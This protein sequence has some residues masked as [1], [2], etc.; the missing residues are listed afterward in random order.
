MKKFS[1]IVLTIILCTSAIFA[2]GA[3]EEAGDKDVTLSVMWFNDANE[4]DVFLDTIQG[5]LE[6]N[7]NV[8]VDMQVVA[9]SEYEQ[10][11][12]LMISG[13]NP[14]DVARVTNN[15][16]ASLGASLEP[17]NNYVDDIEAVKA[18]YMPG[19]IAFAEDKDG[20]LLAYPTEATA[21]GM[22]VNLTAWENA[23]ID[24]RELSK[25]WTWAD[26]EVAV[27][28][29]I[30]AN[31]KMKYG[32][33]LDFSPH[34]FST[35]VFQ[36]GGRFMNS[37]QSAVAADNEGTIAA[38]NMLKKFHDNGVVPTSVWLGSENPAELFQAG[39][40]ACH[41][42]G[43]WNI[44]TYNKNVKDFE[45][46]VVNNPIG[47]VKSSVPGGKFIASFKDSKNKEAAMDLMAAFSAKENN[48]K[49]CADTFNLSARIDAEVPFD[50]NKEDFAVFSE[51]LKVTP[52]YTALEWKADSLN[53]VYSYISEQVVQVLMGNISAE[54]ATRNINK[55]AAKF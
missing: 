32:L 34:R 51:D 21:N 38:I 35:L 11:L 3:K 45:W 5:Y 9:F 14:P 41:I 31:D 15:H 37:D 23:G 48:E 52:A 19:S 22:L 44:N 27:R 54:E 39:L 7:P 42:G 18:D 24:V 13:G 53:K 4:S 28:K 50:S 16:L 20:N 40:V 12:K 2:S 55:E 8:K 36:Y 10:K 30:T 1:L 43:S 33:A 26:W 17:I 49:Y 47:T 46:G 29:V 25:D 6:A